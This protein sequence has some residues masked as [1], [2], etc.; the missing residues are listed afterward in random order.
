M[1]RDHEELRLA[2]HAAA[3]TCKPRLIGLVEGCIHFVKQAEGAGL[4]LKIAKTSAVAARACSPP[5]SSF[6]PAFF[7]PG[8]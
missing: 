8:G 7:L 3:Q 2:R 5:E 6:T 4:S 1:M